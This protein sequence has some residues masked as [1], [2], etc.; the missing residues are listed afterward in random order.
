MNPLAPLPSSP[1]TAASRTFHH[2]GR[3]QSVNTLAGEAG[4]SAGT[5]PVRGC[6]RA[7]VFQCPS[8]HGGLGV[9]LNFVAGS[10]CDALS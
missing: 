8:C 10:W 6:D 4:L 3:P 1:V 5:C 2:P 9:F 7:F